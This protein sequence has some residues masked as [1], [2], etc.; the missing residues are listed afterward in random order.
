MGENS[1]SSR[2][3]SKTKDDLT[4]RRDS[5]AVNWKVYRKNVNRRPGLLNS[6]RNME[7][8]RKVDAG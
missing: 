5:R 3:I 7:E 6:R 1:I 4:I 8:T 2:K